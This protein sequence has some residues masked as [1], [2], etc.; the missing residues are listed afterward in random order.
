M[1]P[2]PCFPHITRKKYYIASAF[3]T[4]SQIY[5]Y[6]YFPLCIQE[7]PWA[8]APRSFS[9]LAQNTADERFFLACYYNGVIS[10][11]DAFFPPR[12]PQNFSISFL[13]FLLSLSAF[14]SN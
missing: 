4:L 5:I 1:L 9:S 7:K 13:A 11:M 8:P 14:P 3:I 6:I 10:S 12:D 2:F